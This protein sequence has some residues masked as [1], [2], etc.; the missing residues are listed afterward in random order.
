MVL[1]TYDIK[2]RQKIKGAIEKNGAKHSICKHN[3]RPVIDVTFLKKWPTIVYYRFTK[4]DTFLSDKLEQ[5]PNTRV[6][7][8]QC[9]S[10]D[11]SRI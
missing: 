7:T 3:P 11:G 10:R 2:I 1:F 9:Q 6:W 8:Y 4:T 5:T